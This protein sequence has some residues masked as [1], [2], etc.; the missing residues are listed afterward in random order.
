MQL[1][2][3]YAQGFDTEREYVSHFGAEGALPELAKAVDATIERVLPDV[4]GTADDAVRAL[5]KQRLMADVL[6]SQWVAPGSAPELR[7]SVGVRGR[8]TALAAV[9]LALLRQY[10]LGMS[11]CSFQ[12]AEVAEVGSVSAGVSVEASCAPLGYLPPAAAPKAAPKAKPARGKSERGG[13]A[14]P[15]GDAS[16]AVWAREN[17]EYRDKVQQSGSVLDPSGTPWPFPA[18]PSAKVALQAPAGTVGRTF[19][20][21]WTARIRIAI[22]PFAV[23]TRVLLR[24]L[25]YAVRT[26]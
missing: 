19:G 2:N 26:T 23:T 14:A 13:S 22:G 24:D 6:N 12:L 4:P 3:T 9:E 25:L 11:E 20:V 10:A 8:A 15:G 18:L 5:L 17:D 21:Q 16:H 7:W 1:M